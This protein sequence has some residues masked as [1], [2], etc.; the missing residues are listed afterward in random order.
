MANILWS[1][2]QLIEA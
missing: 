1:V 2:A